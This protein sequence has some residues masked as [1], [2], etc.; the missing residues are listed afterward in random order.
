MVASKRGTRARCREATTQTM[1]CSV[2]GFALRAYA[3]RRRWHG[4]TAERSSRRP[5]RRGRLNGAIPQ[6]NHGPDISEH[7]GRPR[8][9]DRTLATLVAYL[10]VPPVFCANACLNDIAGRAQL[11]LLFYA[12]AWPFIATTMASQ[13]AM[14]SIH[15]EDAKDTKANQMLNNN[16]SWLRWPLSLCLC[17]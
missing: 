1:T 15:H 8:P 14:S 12:P 13:L 4:C 16:R 10:D 2:D 17:H 3:T 7:T 9:T 5:T 6:H 11:V